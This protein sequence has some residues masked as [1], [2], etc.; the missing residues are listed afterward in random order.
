MN[1]TRDKQPGGDEFHVS[2]SFAELIRLAGVLQWAMVKG[3]RS[4]IAADLVQQTYDLFG[5]EIDFDAA[6]EALRRHERRRP[7]P[8][9]LT[10]P[11]GDYYQAYPDAGALG[12]V[13]PEPD[14]VAI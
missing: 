8:L 9:V 2:L 14:P 10:G 12:L 5:G 4:E 3:A 11:G 1:L 13:A 7:L 6:E